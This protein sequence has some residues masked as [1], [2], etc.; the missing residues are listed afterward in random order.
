MRRFPELV[1]ALGLNGS[2]QEYFLALINNQ[3]RKDDVERDEWADKGVAY[4]VQAYLGKVIEKYEYSRS[5]REIPK[6]QRFSLDFFIGDQKVFIDD[7]RKR[8]V[9]ERANLENQSQ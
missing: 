8:I 2:E 3:L 5:H 7:T 4:R 9:S 6:G 1:E